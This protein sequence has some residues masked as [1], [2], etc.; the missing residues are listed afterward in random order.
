VPT[1]HQ[2]SRRRPSPNW[3]FRAITGD[4]ALK[5][6]DNLFRDPLAGVGASRAQPEPATAEELSVHQHHQGRD[7]SFANV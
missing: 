7:E 6:F 5:P 4:A 1:P 3:I 2:T